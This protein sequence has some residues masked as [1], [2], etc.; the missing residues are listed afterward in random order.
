MGINHNDERI[1]VAADDTK[2]TVVLTLGDVTVSVAMPA[3]VGHKRLAVE[4]L[5]S[6]ALANARRA[7]EMARS[8]LE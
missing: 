4:K 2:V 3:P 1:A 7:L 6:T 5:R 8:E